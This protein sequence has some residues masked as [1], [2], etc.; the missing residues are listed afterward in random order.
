MFPDAPDFKPDEAANLESVL[1]TPGDAPREGASWFRPGNTAVRGTRI[2]RCP[3]MIIGEIYSGFAV[4][5]TVYNIV[6]NYG[7]F[8]TA[9]K[10][11]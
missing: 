2:T 9:K 1:L 10:G 7:E 5:P 6:Y 4:E 11:F 8:L 3:Q